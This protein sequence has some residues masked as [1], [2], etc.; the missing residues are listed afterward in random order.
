MTTYTSSDT[1]K[2]RM[3]NAAGELAAEQGIDNVSTRA[4]AERSGENIGSIHYHFGGKK[5][6]W[7]AVVKT[8]MDSCVQLDAQDELEENATPEKLSKMVRKMIGDEVTNLFRTGRPDWHAQ[9]SYQLLQRDDDLY[10]LFRA[11]R[12]G[13]AMDFMHGLIHIIRP[14]LDDEEVFIIGALIKMPMFAH[15][16][17]RKAMLKRLKVESYSDEYLKKMEDLLVRQAQ[18]LLGLPEDV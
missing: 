3:I 8:A 10:E 2:M 15:A 9:V 6:L 11:W 12:L 18:L 17:Y 5:G 7:V 16:N 4:I 1:T 14:D 13:P